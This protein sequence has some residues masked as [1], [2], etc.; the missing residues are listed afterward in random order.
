MKILRVFKKVMI[1]NLVLTVASLQFFS[2]TSF[3]MG[4]KQPVTPV[5]CDP[6]NIV[7]TGAGIFSCPNM[8]AYLDGFSSNPNSFEIFASCSPSGDSDNGSEL[9]TV[10]AVYPGVN[11]PV[12]PMPN[13]V[14]ISADDFA[15]AISKLSSNCGYISAQTSNT[16]YTITVRPLME[17]PPSP[18]PYPTGE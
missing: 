6:N 8:A 9:L 18:R 17:T 3:A 15:T 12:V 1:R 2:A 4:K 11:K 13:G 14:E 16:E 10:R 7:F 5:A